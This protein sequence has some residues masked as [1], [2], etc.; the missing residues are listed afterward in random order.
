[1]QS[2][3]L[4]SKTFKKKTFWKTIDFVKNLEVT[5]TTGGGFIELFEL[6]PMT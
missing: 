6:L 2:V 3:F 4:L 5:Q 1:M